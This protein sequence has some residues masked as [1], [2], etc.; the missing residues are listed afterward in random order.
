MFITVVLR[1][2]YNYRHPRTARQN[3]YQLCGIPSFIE[4]GHRMLCE[5][6]WRN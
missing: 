1:P 2:I 4:V 6:L 5:L 3:E